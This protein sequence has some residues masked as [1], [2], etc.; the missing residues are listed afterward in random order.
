MKKQSIVYWLIPAK[1]EIELFHGLIKILAKQ[2]GGPLFEPHLTLGMASDAAS[3]KRKLQQLKPRPIRLRLRQV[4]YSSEFR[5]TLFMRLS[6]SPAL[7]KLIVDLTGKSK[8]STDL[9]VSLVYKKMSVRAQKELAKTLK[10]P[11]REIV[12]D[13]I[14]VMRC[15]SPTKSAADVRAW[16]Q[17]ATKKLVNGR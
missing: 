13:S 15:A 12:F 4:D 9:H 6:P 11:F 5:K 2:L 14:R 7:K 1:P 8:P 16:R 3:A 10:L 17:L